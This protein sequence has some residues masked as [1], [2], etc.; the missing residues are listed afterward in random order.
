[1]SPEKNPAVTATASLTT[2][3]TSS[4]TVPSVTAWRVLSSAGMRD[5][6][7][8]RL[9]ILTARGLRSKMIVNAASPLR[10]AAGQDETVS[11]PQDFTLSIPG[12]DLAGLTLELSSEDG[13]KELGWPRTPSPSN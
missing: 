4:W 6:R 3:D 12:T 8:R 9:K 7:A 2:R 11:T 5:R 13:R 1:M 10:R